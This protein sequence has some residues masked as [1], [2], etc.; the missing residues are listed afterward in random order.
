MTIFPAIDIKGGRCVRLTK[1]AFETAEQVADDPLEAA[2][3]FRAAGAEWVHMVDLDGAVSGRRVNPAIFALVAEKS[4]LKVQLGGGIRDM[5][6]VEYYISRGISRVVLGSAAVRDPGFAK[7][8]VEKYGERIAVGV[9]ALDG[10][11]RTAG[12]LDESGEG[13]LEFSMKMEAAGVKTIIFTDIS[14]DGAMAGPNFGQLEAL[15]AAVGCDIIA[16]G[17][18]TTIEDVKRLAASG[19]YGAI[20]GKAIYKG[21][22]QLGEAISL[23]AGAAG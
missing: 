18:V 8:A 7:R 1:G 19:L 17:G 3:G 13:Y 2:A 10:I 15:Q 16:S 22:L 20:C 5:E 11:V 14:K 21:T 6:A 23:A 9:D 12:W 4:G